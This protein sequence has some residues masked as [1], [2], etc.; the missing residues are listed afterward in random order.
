M[1]ML[2]SAKR[3]EWEEQK[4]PTPY[5]GSSIILFDVVKVKL[6]PLIVNPIYSNQSMVIISETWDKKR[7]KHTINLYYKRTPKPELE[8][9]LIKS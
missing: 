8:G 7:I 6:E 2:D 4:L 1:E 9:T 5:L 3:E